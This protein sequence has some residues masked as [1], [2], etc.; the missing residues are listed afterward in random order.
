MAYVWSWAFG[1]ET[2]A[3]LNSLTGWTITNTNTSYAQES[4]TIKHSYVGD[5]TDRHSFGLRGNGFAQT[6]TLLAP[7]GY[8]S[9]YFYYNGTADWGNYEMLQIQG[10]TSDRQIELRGV[11]G[12]TLTLKI[13]GT[14]VEFTSSAGHQFTDATWHHLGIKYDMLTDNGPWT[15]EIFADGVSLISGSTSNSVLD[16]ESDCQIWFGGVRNSTAPQDSIFWSDIILY[17]D[18]GDADPH[19]QYVSRIQPARDL[20]ES[21]SWSPAS[22][23]VAIPGDQATRLS[24]AIATTPV[25]SE[26]DPT[27]GEFV[28]IR[29]DSL[30]S[31]LGLTSFNSYGFTAHLFA[32]GSS[33]TNLIPKF[34]NG[35]EATVVGTSVIDG[36]NAYAWA[37]S[38]SNSYVSSSL[39]RYEV[40]VSGS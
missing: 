6:P 12:K 3:E 5:Q 37:S 11:T 9:C 20:S 24:G 10:P 18:H 1:P 32:S 4:N 21:G 22:N 25:V 34:Q 39:M 13:G 38:G 31:S 30:G 29:A 7:R 26:A 23:P 36:I 8:L 19:G 14:G 17:D 33:A 28:S 40:E 2:A 16:A 27:T 15:T 35:A